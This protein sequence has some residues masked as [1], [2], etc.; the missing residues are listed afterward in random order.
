MFSQ[1]LAE[2]KLKIG[3]ICCYECICD[4]ASTMGLRQKLLKFLLVKLLAL[5][6]LLLN[7]PEIMPMDGYALRRECIV[8]FVN[9]LLIQEIAVTPLLL[10]FLFRLKLMII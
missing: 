7:F 6:V 2:L 4:G 1:V 9:L 8:W 3:L 5:K 10:P